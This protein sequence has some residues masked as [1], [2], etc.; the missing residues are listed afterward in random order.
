MQEADNLKPNDTTAFIEANT[1]FQATPLCPE[2]EVRLLRPDASMWKSANHIFDDNGPRPYWAFAWGS[3]QSLA[4]F[5]LDHP[6]VVLGR[7]VFDFGSGCGIA[8]IASAKAGACQVIATEIDSVAVRAI[9]LNAQHNGVVVQTRATT[10]DAQ[11][12]LPQARQLPAA[13]IPFQ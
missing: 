12:P 3:G 9:E 2:I 1:H 4:R 11:Q 7:R 10:P 8:A 5:V 6:E 13:G